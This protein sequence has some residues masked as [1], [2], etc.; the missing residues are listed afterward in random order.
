M[1]LTRFFVAGM[2]GAFALSAQAAPAWTDWNSLNNGTLTQGS[3]VTNVTLT[4]VAYNYDN[5]APFYYQ[6]PATFGNLNPSDLIREV[7]TGNVTLNFDKPVT[8]L[9]LALVSVGQPGLPVTYSFNNAFSVFSSGP[10]GWGGGSYSIS[11]N[12]F[13]GSEFNG[14]L[15]FSGTFSSLSFSINQPENW[16][17]FN[18]AA[19][20]VPEPDTLA[21]LA[22]AGI[23]ALGARRKR[24][25]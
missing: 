18:I 23:G 25:I 20:D 13:T 19:A 17:G 7:G 24:S 14:V 3:H 15:F 16:H 21:L 2:F 22:L 6:Y 12:D 1:K 5:G 4:G 9:Y 11:G 10:G 8:D